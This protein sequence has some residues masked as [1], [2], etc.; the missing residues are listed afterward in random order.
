MK[1]AALNPPAAN[2]LR[3]SYGEPGIIG[4]DKATGK[5]TI[6]G[7]CNHHQ[8]HIR[9]TDGRVFDCGGCSRKWCIDCDKP[10]HEHQSCKEYRDRVEEALRVKHP[11]RFLVKKNKELVEMEIIVSLAEADRDTEKALTSKVCKR[12]PMCHAYLWREAGCAYSQ[13][14]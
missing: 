11:F 5:A 13:C 14:E 7:V 9:A 1:E 6:I 10:E 4:H 12:C 8:R 3:C 2:S